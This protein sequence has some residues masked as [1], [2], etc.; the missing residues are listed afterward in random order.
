MKHSLSSRTSSPPSRPN[1]RLIRSRHSTVIGE[2]S[3]VHDTPW[4]NGVAE[5][6]NR[7]LLEHARAMLLASGLPKSLWVDAVQHANWLRNRLSTKPIGRTPFEVL[8]GEKPDLG[9]ARVWGSRV[10][11][12]AK[13]SDKLNR[14]GLEARWIGLSS[15]SKG[16]HR[17]YWPNGSI[18]VERDVVFAEDQF[19]GPESST[20]N[21]IQLNSHHPRLRPLHHPPQL[22]KPWK[23]RRRHPQRSLRVTSTLWNE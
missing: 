6:L 15:E 13:E 18:S 3:S 10:F 22:Q 17:I 14:R 21:D 1:I 4:A 2:E 12:K 7:T 9:L 8:K 19:P 11:V 23:I 16:G 20:A 5:R